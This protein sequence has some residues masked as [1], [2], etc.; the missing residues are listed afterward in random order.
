MTPTGTCHP[1]SKS[2]F[3]STDSRILPCERIE[4]RFALGHINDDVILDFKSIADKYNRFYDNMKSL[5]LSCYNLKS[6][7]KCMFNCKVEASEPVCNHYSS[8]KDF[9]KKLSDNIGYMED[10][11]EIYFK[12]L[13]E[14]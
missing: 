8:Q 5:C 2:I 14:L 11:P 10:K 7:K 9:L 12:H 1:F 6:C 4:H 3:L 13:N